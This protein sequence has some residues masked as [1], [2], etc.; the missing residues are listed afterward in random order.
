M[1]ASLSNVRVRDTGAKML[2]TRR[3]KRMRLASNLRPPPHLSLSALLLRDNNGYWSLKAS[4][5]SMSSGL[6]IEKERSTPWK[7]GKIRLARRVMTKRNLVGFRLQA[8]EV[9]IFL[10]SKSKEGEYTYSKIS[11]RICTKLSDVKP[12]W[13]LFD[14]GYFLIW[15]NIWQITRQSR[16]LL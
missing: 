1:K 5:L 11:S 4:Q 16:A 3:H 13:V 14:L 6:F 8:Q 10:D 7:K 12:N 15:V 9:R 2:K